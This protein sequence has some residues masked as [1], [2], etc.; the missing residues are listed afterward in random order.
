MAWQSN[1]AIV[2]S[3]SPP[4]TKTTTT[5]ELFQW[6]GGC[7]LGGCGYLVAQPGLRK[8]GGRRASS[9]LSCL[10]LHLPFSLRPPHP[11]KGQ[12][13]QLQRPSLKSH[14]S[15]PGAANLRRPGPPQACGVGVPGGEP[16]HQLPSESNTWQ[17]PKPPCRPI[18][19]QGD[20]SVVLV[21]VQGQGSAGPIRLRCHRLR[22]LRPP[23]TG[24]RCRVGA[25]VESLQR[26]GLLS[27]ALPAPG[28]GVGHSRLV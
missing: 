15:A 27:P 20:S 6:Q 1:K 3:F 10:F 12:K 24:S 25:P 16:G 17:D 21:M 5:T 19:P 22:L 14:S 11:A 4:P 13:M 9:R 2:F 8:G 28:G 23:C 7:L 26:C 18:R